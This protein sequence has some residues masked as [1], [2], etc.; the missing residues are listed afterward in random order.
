[1]GCT[2]DK[3]AERRRF[4]TP[5]IS[6]LGIL[7]SGASATVRAFE[8]AVFGDQVPAKWERFWPDPGAVRPRRLPRIRQTTF[9]DVTGLNIVSPAQLQIHSI[10]MSPKYDDFI[11]FEKNECQNGGVKMRGREREKGEGKRKR[12]E[13]RR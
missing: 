10:W 1:M 9:N 8:A 3:T 7:N 5:E 6:H 13:K 11:G 4:P 12:G 2:M